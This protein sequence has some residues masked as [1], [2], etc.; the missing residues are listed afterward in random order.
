MQQKPMPCRPKDVPS[1]NLVSVVTQLAKITITESYDRPGKSTQQAVTMPK[2]KPP[3]AA[4]QFSV[5]LL[6]IVVLLPD[7]MPLRERH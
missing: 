1:H 2:A 7:Q 4:I 3:I 6:S 5:F